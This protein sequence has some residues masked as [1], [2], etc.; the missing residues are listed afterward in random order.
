MWPVSTSSRDS[1]VP[2]ASAADLRIRETEDLGVEV[3]PLGPDA[4]DHAPLEDVLQL[5]DV[6]RPRVR[7]EPGERPRV[8]PLESLPEPAGIFL[9]R[10]TWPGA[11]CPRR[12]RGAA[13]AGSG[14]RSGG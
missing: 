3:E 9:R 13:G 11:G 6:T 2:E 12:D 4:E 1:S 5:P 8:D 14:T 10:K 7:R